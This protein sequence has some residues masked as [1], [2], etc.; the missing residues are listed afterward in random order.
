MTHV[1]ACVELGVIQRSK[2]L[3]GHVVTLMH[4]N[5]TSTDAPSS[6]FI[7]MEHTLV[8]YHIEKWDYQ[9]S[10]VVIKLQGVDNAEAA[11]HLKGCSLFVTREVMAKLAPQEPRLL[12]GYRVVEIQAGEL[13]SVRDLY[14]TPLQQLL[15]IDHQ[16]R[17]LLVPYHEDIV[18]H[19]D[20][21]AQR[22]DVQLPQ[23]FLD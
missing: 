11:H 8:P 2:G 1:E 6:I 17:E 10:K 14:A 22:I 15:A 12:I 20:D 7:Q 13:G 9:S 23:G 3:K 18:V 21:D 4:H 16:G 19:V 5:I